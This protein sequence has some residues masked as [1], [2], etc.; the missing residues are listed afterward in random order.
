ML[1]KVEP[2]SNI[3]FGYAGRNNFINDDYMIQ[4]FMKNSSFASNNLIQEMHLFIEHITE[5]E[6]TTPNAEEL[7]MVV[8]KEY[9]QIKRFKSR[10]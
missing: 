6:G 1:T 5:T 10:I 7:V 8:I 3:H 2:K 9:N 4:F